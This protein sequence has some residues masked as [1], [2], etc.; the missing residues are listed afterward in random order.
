MGGRTFRSLDDVI[1]LNSLGVSLPVAEIF[2]RR[3]GGVLAGH[4][5]EEGR[6]DGAARFVPPCRSWYGAVG[7]GAGVASADRPAEAGEMLEETVRSG[8]GAEAG[9]VHGP[10]NPGIESVLPAEFMGLATVFSAENVTSGITELKELASFCGLPLK[11][12]SAFTPARL[13]LHEVLVRVMADLQ[14]PD[15]D[16]YEDLGINFRAMTARI[17]TGYVEPEFVAITAL[18]ERVKADAG[19]FLDRVQDHAPGAAGTAPARAGL[20]SAFRRGEGRAARPPENADVARIDGWRRKAQ[21]AGRPFERACCQALVAAAEAVFAV[22]G[23]LLH[24]RRLTTEVALRLFCND[25]GSRA[26]G[27]RLAP[28][29]ARAAAA[30][31]FR[32]LPRQSSPVVMNVKGASA[33]GKSTLRPL[34]KKLAREVG[35]A[36]EDFALISPDIW[37]K[38][39]L[40]YNSLGR[41][42][43]YAGTLTAAEVGIIDRKLDRY[44]SDKDR[45]GA[46][47]HL[48]IDRFRFDSFAPD[49]E[50]GSRLLTRFGSDVFMFFMITPPEATVERAWKRGEQFGRYKAVDDLLAHNVEAYSGIPGLFFTWVLRQDKCVHFEF[51]DNGVAEGERPRTVAY[52]LN[53]RMN[54]L[55]LTCFLDIDRYRHVNV[56]AHT[57]EAIYARP[58]SRCAAKDPAFLKQCLRRLPAVV[59]AEQRTGQVWAHVAGGRLRYWDRDV[60]ESAVRDGDSRAAFEGVAGSLPRD[61]AQ[62]SAAGAGRLD[63]AES[64]TLGQWCAGAPG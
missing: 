39:L 25:Y 47:P 4:L 36:W 61:A 5:K 3:R 31:G 23:R 46:L 27:E 20:F 10:W 33:S 29:L 45:L 12:L 55:D 11:R 15:G 57:R 56:D 14:V 26:V 28:L 53:G 17:M 60:Y 30:E 34:Q 35:V 1:E 6:K 62:G 63:P 44:M 37:R 48:L 7:G 8:G 16:R 9:E 24:D 22:H 59:F 21:E 43:K 40:D 52:G 18:F 2:L 51:L 54:I 50:D 41:A 32:P 19:D 13:A 42:R 58:A 49:E 38:Y 64:L